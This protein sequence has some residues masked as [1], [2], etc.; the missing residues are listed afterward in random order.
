MLG[1]LVKALQKSDSFQFT[2]MMNGMN[3]I[4]N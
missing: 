2:N 4:T 3:F 1:R